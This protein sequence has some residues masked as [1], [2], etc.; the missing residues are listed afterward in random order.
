MA[1][2]LQDFFCECFLRN[3]AP[4]TFFNWTG[5]PAV[6][7]NAKVR[8]TTNSVNRNHYLIL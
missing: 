4:V 7:R 8:L 2:G 3:V 6:R 1:D 5:I